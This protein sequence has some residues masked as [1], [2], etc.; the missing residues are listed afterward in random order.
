MSLYGVAVT[1]PD[2][3]MLEAVQNSETIGSINRAAGGARQVLKES[4]LADW[5]KAEC[6]GDAR[7]FAEAQNRFALSCAAYW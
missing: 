3:G 5:L 4:V 2:Q 7:K 1:G 6:G